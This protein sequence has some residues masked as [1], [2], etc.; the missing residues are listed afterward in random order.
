MEFNIQD[1]L[2]RGFEFGNTNC[3]VSED[4]LLSQVCIN[5]ILFGVSYYEGVLKIENFPSLMS[6]SSTPTEVYLDEN[7]ILKLR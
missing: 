3:N 6:S 5:T 4:T 1:Q 2:I 7:K